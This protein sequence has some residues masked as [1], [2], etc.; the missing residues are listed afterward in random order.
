[1]NTQTQ[2]RQPRPGTFRRLE[3]LYRVNIIQ[4]GR[5]GRFLITASFLSTFAS[6]RFIT[7]S[8]RAGRFRFLFRNLSVSH[9]T[10]LHH[11]V[12][13]ILGLLGSGYTSIGFTPRNRWAR[14]GLAGLFGAAAALTLDEFALWLN[15]QDVYWAREGRE[16][17]DAVVI[18]S[19]LSFLVLEGRSLLRAMARDTAWLLR[20][21]SERGRVPPARAT[22]VG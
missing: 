19:G 1:M 21:D 20:R 14:R 2:R 7:H 18:A 4:Q 12:L 5:A 13:G 9:G 22:D 15:L 8:I 11:L 16:S 10:H 3:E 17:I 6:V